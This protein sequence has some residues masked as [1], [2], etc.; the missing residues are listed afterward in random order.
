[1]TLS[2]ILLVG[3]QASELCIAGGLARELGADV[4]LASSG[5]A[6]LSIVREH[7]CDM[8]L[9]EVTVDVAAIIRRLRSAGFTMPVLACGVGASAEAAVAAVRAGAR[10]FVPLPP[11][12]ALISAILQD[13]VERPAALTGRDPQFVQAVHL[14]VRL[15]ASARAMLILGEPGTGKQLLAW[16]VHR[17]Q[18][19]GPF[20]TVDCRAL[21]AGRLEADLFGQADGVIR[22]GALAQAQGGTLLLRHVERLSYGLRTRLLSGPNEGVRLIATSTASSPTSSGEDALAPDLVDS[23]ADGQLWLPPLRERGGDVELLGGELSARAG[24]RLGLPVPPMGEDCLPALRRYSWPGNVRE[25]EVVVTRA[26]LLAFGRPITAADLLSSA[27]QPLASVGA[28][29]VNALVGHKMDAVERALILET[30]Q[31]CSGNRTVASQLLGISVRT[32]RNKLRA[33]IN[34]GIAVPPAA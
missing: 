7:G 4:R 1:M 33:F 32:M 10:D 9:V 22:A 20:I 25:L 5:D 34:D 6:A 27:G 24:A 11:T 28:A 23:F 19:Q 17:Q 29:R 16:H 30:L 2:R 13:I 18:G 12:R 14:G 21:D 3:G 15:A 8:A 31:R 26:T